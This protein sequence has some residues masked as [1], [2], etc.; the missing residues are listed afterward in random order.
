MESRRRQRKNDSTAKTLISA[1]V[2]IAVMVCAVFVLLSVYRRIKS[3]YQSIDFSKPSESP[4]QQTLAIENEKTVGW[5]ET[6]KG[7][8]YYTEKDEYLKDTWKEIDGFLYHFDE[9]G[10]MTQGDWSENGQKFTLSQKGYVKNIQTDL[11]WE[12]ETAS[13]TLDSLVKA[14]T[15]F[16]YLG[17]ADGAFKPILYRKAADTKVI[18]LGG[19][20]SP[21]TTTRNSLRADGDYVYYLPK[22]KSAQ[23]AALTEKERKVCD[24]LFRFRPGED[25]VE[26]IAEDVDG[27][28]IVDG[29]IYYAQGGSLH[30][31]V[32]GKVVDRGDSDS[33]YQV[34]VRDKNA[35]LADGE[36]KI[37]TAESGTTI[38]LG[39]RIYRIE[40][41]GKIRYVK[42]AEESVGGYTYSLSA[43]SGSNLGI[44]RENSAGSQV[45]AQEKYGVQSYC[46]VD[47]SIFYSA[48][49]DHDASGVWYSQIFRVAL[50]GSGK[51]ALG[52]RF[53]GMVGNMYSFEDEG[54]YG[55]YHPTSWKNGYGVIVNI[56]KDGSFYQIKDENLR[57]KKTTSGND[58][59]ELLMVTDGTVSALW[60]DTAWSKNVGITATLWS[61]GVQMSANE[62]VSVGDGS[63]FQEKEEETQPQT[64]AAPETTEQI[65]VRPVEETS[66]PQTQPATT[67]EVIETLPIAPETDAAQTVSP[68]NDAPTTAAPA[69]EVIIQPIN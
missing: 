61:E 44:L 57:A 49:V 15:Y 4:V 18:T 62:R 28:L 55:E 26:L 8:F 40:T 1:L 45:V 56:K 20:E 2:A 14:N 7:F 38:T 41:D 6:E 13:E 64:T 22:V 10:V 37:V 29:V 42:H 9:D 47:N 24:K 68:G 19:E 69:D 53:Y 27:Y 23:T 48:Y 32:S 25:Q 50:D 33:A 11:S 67:Q 60:H 54:I 46:I 3:D 63:I 12:P 65:I 51:T 59:M 21:E 36:G 34:I 16:C 39:D 5:H 58:G 30:R 31:A 35:Y 66:A 43:V 52:S 17:E